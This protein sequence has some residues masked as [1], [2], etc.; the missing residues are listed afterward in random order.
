[1]KRTVIRKTPAVLAVLT[2][3][4]VIPVSGFSTVA[5]AAPKTDTT[6]QNAASAQTDVYVMTKASATSD[7]NSQ[8]YL[9]RYDK[10]RNISKIYLN[11]DKSAKSYDQKNVYQYRGSDLRTVVT[12]GPDHKISDTRQYAYNGNGQRHFEFTFY[13]DARKFTFSSTDKSVKYHSSVE[14]FY[15]KKNQMNKYTYKVWDKNYKVTDSGIVK[16]SYNKAGKIKTEKL[17][18]TKGVLASRSTF[19][20]DANGNCTVKKIYAADGSLQQQYNFE[21]TYDENKNLTESV[22]TVEGDGGS[23]EVTL[24]LNYKKVTV[25]QSA[26]AGIRAQQQDFLESL[27]S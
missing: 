9:L 12:Y 26:A 23:S 4:T 17:Y 8:N 27:Q 13:G 6:A 3:A 24:K 18:H 22:M 10:D 21:N 1:M 16:V 7:E 15:N 5:Q 11:Y 20:Y 19:S 25:G 14:Y 2:A